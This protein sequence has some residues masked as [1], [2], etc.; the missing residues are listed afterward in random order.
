MAELGLQTGCLE[1]KV[2]GLDHHAYFTKV[3]FVTFYLCHNKVVFPKSI[4]VKTFFAYV[5]I[6]KFLWFLECNLRSSCLKAINLY[7]LIRN[8]FTVAV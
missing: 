2:S 6:L 5:Y 7:V 8:G 4:W 3:G 1:Y